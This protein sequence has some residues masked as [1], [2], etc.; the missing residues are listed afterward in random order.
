MRFWL[1]KARIYFSNLYL[2]IPNMT[3]WGQIYMDTGGPLIAVTTE[4]VFDMEYILQNWWRT[5]ITTQTFCLSCCN[6][7]C[8]VNAQSFQALKHRD[9]LYV[10]LSKHVHRWLWCFLGG[11]QK[12]QV[13]FR[14][15]RSSSCR[16]TPRLD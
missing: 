4:G 12:K 5:W 9:L 6:Q 16:R 13:S 3:F 7:K 10:T 8:S 14:R 15:Y 1:I 2:H 11:I